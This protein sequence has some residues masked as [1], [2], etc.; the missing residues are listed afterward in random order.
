MCGIYSCE[1]SAER[2]VPGKVECRTENRS[3]KRGKC[4]RMRAA[5]PSWGRMAQKEAHP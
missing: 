2:W 4:A 3:R 1:V 5:K